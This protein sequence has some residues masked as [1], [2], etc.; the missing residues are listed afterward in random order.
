MPRTV[1]LHVLVMIKGRRVPRPQTA[2]LSPTMKENILK[3]LRVDTRDKEANSL[4]L[5]APSYC[6]QCLSTNIKGVHTHTPCVVIVG[7]C[8]DARTVYAG[9][10]LY[11]SYKCRA[12]H[13]DVSGFCIVACWCLVGLHA[14]T[15]RY[16]V[17]CYYRV[18]PQC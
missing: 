8:M 10:S 7:L 4:P 16:L 1:P 13:V 9:L 5:A 6:A 11:S 17:G 2:V 18:A 15:G 3:K 14:D 12:A